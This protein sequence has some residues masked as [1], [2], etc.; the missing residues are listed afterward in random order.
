MIA[1]PR[2]VGRFKVDSFFFENMRAGE[3]VNLFHDMIVLDVQRNFND[4]SREYIAVHPSFRRVGQGEK[5]PEY[6]AI[7]HYHEGATSLPEWQEL[8]HPKEPTHEEITA[9]LRSSLARDNERARNTSRGT[10]TSA[11][12]HDQRRDSLNQLYRHFNIRRVHWWDRLLQRGLTK[13][14]ALLGRRDTAAGN[15]VP[16]GRQQLRAD[17]VGA[18]HGG[19]EHDAYGD[20][21]LGQSSWRDEAG[22]I[23]AAAQAAGV[24]ADPSARGDTGRITGAQG[25]IEEGR[26][27]YK[28]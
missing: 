15:D 23:A 20:G 4:S 14:R 16:E 3:G 8:H 27:R 6:V 13:L 7:F 24:G 26:S 22:A 25:F 9:A 21:M 11:E 1:Y 28:T 2:N 12:F 10:Y 18:V 19:F 17:R 5:I